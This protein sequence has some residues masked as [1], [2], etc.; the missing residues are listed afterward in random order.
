MLLWRLEKQTVIP[1]VAGGR[2]AD[3]ENTHPP[4]N[5]QEVLTGFWNA[6]C[7]CALVLGS[8]REQPC[9]TFCEARSETRLLVCPPRLQTHTSQKSLHVVISY[10]S[11]LF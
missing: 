8:T 3:Q 4:T 10:H 9:M 5:P 6:E 1:E 11:G 7:K 2:K